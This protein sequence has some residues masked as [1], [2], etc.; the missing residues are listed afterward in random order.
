MFDGNPEAG[1][2][3]LSGDGAGRAALSFAAPAINPDTQL[4][5]ITN[6]GVAQFPTPLGTLGEWNYDCVMRGA[7]GA[8]TASFS[9]NPEPITVYRAYIGRI[10]EGRFTIDHD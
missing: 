2:F 8:N 9:A 5:T 6:E 3:E 10:F 1:G 7:T 4:M